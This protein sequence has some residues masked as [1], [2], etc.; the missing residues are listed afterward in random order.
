[1]RGVYH[2]ALSI[3][4]MHYVYVLETVATPKKRYVGFTGDLRARL[5]DH[6]CGKNVST[7]ALRP[8][9]L[10]TYIGF[11]D[12]ERALE[13]ERY[14]KSGSGHAFLNKRL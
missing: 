9:S 13:F 11:G 14:L 7:A 5:R 12:K 2:D 6:N 4:F 3:P 1:M 8:W 10:R